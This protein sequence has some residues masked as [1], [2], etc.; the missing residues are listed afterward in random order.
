MNLVVLSFVNPLKMLNQT[1]TGLKNMIPR[2]MTQ[3]VVDYFKERGN[4]R[5]A[6]D[7]RH[8]LHR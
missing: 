3:E 6:V 8:H 2:G 7:W 4:P 1:D 5:H